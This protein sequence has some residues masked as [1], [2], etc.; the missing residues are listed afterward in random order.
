VIRN[1]YIL[2]FPAEFGPSDPFIQ[3]NRR[4]A[5]S[6]VP[7]VRAAK[8]QR[9]AP[10]RGLDPYVLVLLADQEIRADRLSEARCLIEAAYAA[11]DRC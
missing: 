10:A 11:Y 2:R 7:P 6:P 4:T 5:Y 1:F 8:R 9:P 3:K